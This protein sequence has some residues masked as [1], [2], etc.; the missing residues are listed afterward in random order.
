M[1][2]S[3]DN[4]MCQLC[5][6]QEGIISNR[7]QMKTDEILQQEITNALKCEPITTNC[8][9]SVLSNNGEITLIGL[10]DNATKKKEAENIATTIGGVVLVINKIDIKLNDW[11]E[12]KD[13]EL[14][15]EIVSAFK[16]NWKTLNDTIKVLVLNGW[17]TLSGEVEWNYQKEAAK[18]AVINLI[19]VKG[20]SNNIVIK[21]QSHFKI[22]K[23][24]LKLA[25]QNHLSLDSKDIEIEVLD[26][27]ITLKGT[28]DS[29]C[30]KEIADRI[31]W[32]TPGVINVNNELVIENNKYKL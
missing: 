24:A 8:N 28:V 4:C 17:V 20:V 32:K 7:D 13:I 5:I 1:L 21:S 26:S 11:D 27:N 14:T 9:L 6:I 2:I 16:W 12:K 3:I 30:Q 15:A 29:W 18:E 19:G 31:A 10:V 23:T 25:L 22:D